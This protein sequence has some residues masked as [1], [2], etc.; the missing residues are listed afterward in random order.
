M[1]KKQLA[2]KQIIDTKPVIGQT[3]KKYRAVLRRKYLGEVYVPN[4]VKND[5]FTE[6]LDLYHSMIIKYPNS[7]SAKVSYQYAII[8]GRIDLNSLDEQCYVY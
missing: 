6:Y 8:V 4:H 1:S 5:D 2:L 3:I 7:G